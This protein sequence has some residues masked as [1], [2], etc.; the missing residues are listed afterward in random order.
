MRCKVRA[1]LEAG[2]CRDTSRNPPDALQCPARA[3]SS[4]PLSDSTVSPAR[5]P[6]AALTDADR[7]AHRKETQLEPQSNRRTPPALPGRPETARPPCAPD[8]I[9]RSIRRRDKRARSA[10]EI[11]R[12]GTAQTRQVKTEPP[13]MQHEIYYATCGSSE[14]KPKPNPRF[15]L[16]SF[17]SE[18][19]PPPSPPRIAPACRG[20]R[21]V[22]PQV[23]PLW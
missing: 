22:G 17:V 2:R 11:R 7:G 5:A 1:Y 18:Q 13:Q 21:C 9:E 12:S 14:A 15:S 23:P 8:D 16:R 6:G 19:N 3:R 4:R 20:R 10:G